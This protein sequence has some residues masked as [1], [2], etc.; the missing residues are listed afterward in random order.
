L[1]LYEG[2]R[3]NDIHGYFGSALKKE[4]GYSFMH[5]L[6]NHTIALYISFF[7]PELHISNGISIAA[8]RVLHC[9]IRFDP[10]PLA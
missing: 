9:I 8:S 10:E 6:G 7:Y 2:S 1:Y 4:L 5:P 3:G